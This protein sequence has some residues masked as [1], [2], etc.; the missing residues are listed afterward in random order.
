M[1]R[2]PIRRRTPLATGRKPMRA[3]RPE[4]AASKRAFREAVL[5]RDTFCRMCGVAR[6]TD[7][8]HILPRGRGGTDSPDNGAG[9][10]WLCHDYITHT[11][12]GIRE[13]RE[14]GLIASAKGGG[15]G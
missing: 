5:A 15:E 8:H 11:A 6:A 10:C 4:R 2:S 13:G 7:P 1:K 3:I 14:R 12:E 9:L